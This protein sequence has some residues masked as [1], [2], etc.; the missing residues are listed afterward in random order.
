ML[1]R[2]VFWI[3]LACA[4]L[5]IAKAS[6]TPSSWFNDYKNHQHSDPFL[7]IESLEK[8]LNENNQSD[9]AIDGEAYFRLTQLYFKVGRTTQAK[10]TIEL[11]KSQEEQLSEQG[12]VWLG[13]AQVSGLLAEVKVDPARAI[14]IDIKSDALNNNKTMAAYFYYLEGQQRSLNSLYEDAISDLNEAGIIAESIDETY[15]QLGVLS[16]LVNIQ[17]YMEQYE[18]SLKTNQLLAEKALSLN[19]NFI[20]IFTYSNAMN[21]YYMMAN[22]KNMEIG[23]LTDQSDIDRAEA[24]RQDYIQKSTFYRNKIFDEAREVGAFKPYLRAKIQLQN[25]FLREE[26]FDKAIQTAKESIETAEKYNSPFEKAVSYNNLSIALRAQEKYEEAIE[27]LKQAEVIYREMQQEQSILWALEDYSIIY[28]LKGDFE[29]ALDYRKQLHN[30]SMALVRK[31][32]NDKVLELQKIFESEKKQREID[33]LHQINQL[34]ETKLSDQRAILALSVTSVIFVVIALFLAYRR[35]KDIAN[36]N[37]LL[38]ELNSKLKEQALRDPLTKLYNRRFINEVQYKLVS[39]ALREKNRSKRK[40]GLVLLDIDHFKAVNDQYGHDTGDQVLLSVANELTHSLRSEDIA[41]RWGG[42]EFLVILTDTDEHGITQFCERML[43][44]RSSQTVNLKGQS[45]T[46]TTSLG[47]LLFPFSTGEESSLTW[48]ESLKLLDNLLYLAKE[49]GRNQ[50][51][52]IKNH[53]SSLSEEDK[54]NLLSL[55]ASYDGRIFAAKGIAVDWLKPQS[56]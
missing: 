16:H 30:E 36:K 45:L 38:D 54:K 34:N 17:Y 31:T 8:W 39:R 5:L 33:R 27:A 28:E 19:D 6:A 48:D 50:G 10:S 22:K 40:L 12:K 29:A 53:K 25:E 7:A 32:N 52:T 26:D 35:N 51:A 15:I 46:V 3:L 11:L 49:N 56:Q 55:Q 14:L 4:A 2:A 21:I 1:N 13:L 43:N 47:Y 23:I 42:E 44:S 20:R 9:V 18:E 24:I 41:V 37:A